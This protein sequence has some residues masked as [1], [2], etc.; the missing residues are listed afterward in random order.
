MADEPL[1]V[2][3]VRQTPD[4]TFLVQDWFKDAQSKSRVRSAVELVL[5][6][7]LPRSYDRILFTAKCN[8]VFDLM[9]DYATQGLKWPGSGGTSASFH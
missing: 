3:V 5:D 1:E 4:G 6:N 2:L 8:N 7:N 9:V